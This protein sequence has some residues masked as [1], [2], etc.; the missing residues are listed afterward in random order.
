MYGANPY[1]VIDL[2]TVSY[3]R[4]KKMQEIIEYF[5]EIQHVPTLVLWLLPLV[6]II[7]TMALMMLHDDMR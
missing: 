6:S 2:G 7:A 5:F 3:K 1:R 4:D